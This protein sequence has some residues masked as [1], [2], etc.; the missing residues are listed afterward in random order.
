MTLTQRIL[1]S[2]GKGATS[3][4]LARRLNHDQCAIASILTMKSKVG[5]V[6]VIGTRTLNCRPEFIYRR[7]AKGDSWPQKK[8]D[9]PQAQVRV[10]VAGR[11]EIGR[12]YNWNAEW[13]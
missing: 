8:R 3:G 5:V 13:A 11:I 7:T 4:E 9:K 12:G 1:D 2:L 6:E 10:G